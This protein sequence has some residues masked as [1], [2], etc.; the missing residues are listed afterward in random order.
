MLLYQKENTVT[1]E[2]AANLSPEE[3]A[4]KLIVGVF[5]DKEQSDYQTH[6]QAVINKSRMVVK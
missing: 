6:Y 1:I 4:N 3:L 2:K 5:V